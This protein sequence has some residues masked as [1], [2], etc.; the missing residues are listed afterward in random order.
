MGS[1]GVVLGERS[2]EE[3]SLGLYDTMNLAITVLKLE[4]SPVPHLN[5]RVVQISIA[6]LP[7]P[8]GRVFQW[9]SIAL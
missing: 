7:L 4:T 1:L 3:S 9:F 6:A 5:C 2:Y 8:G